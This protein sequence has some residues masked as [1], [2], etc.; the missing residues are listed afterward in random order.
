[1]YL[2]EKERKKLERQRTRKIE[3]LEQNIVQFEEEIATLEDQ[4]C[5]PEIYADYEKTSEIT[6][7]KQ[8]LQE[9]L[10]ACMAEWEE[11]H[12]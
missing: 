11:L 5:L 12:L 9:Q 7:K 6:T 10:D 3:E 4:L 2:E 8:T 1:N